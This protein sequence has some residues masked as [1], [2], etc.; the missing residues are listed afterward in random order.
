MSK[1]W[2][3]E[4]YRRIKV[5][6]TVD[7]DTAEEAVQRAKDGGYIDVDTEPDRDLHRPAWSARLKERPQP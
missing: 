1:M 4:G 6:M 3:V 7:A 5:W 2:R